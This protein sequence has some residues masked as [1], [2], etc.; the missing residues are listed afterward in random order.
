MITNAE[1]YDGVFHTLDEGSCVWGTAFT[2]VVDE[3]GPGEW[4]GRKLTRKVVEKNSRY[5]NGENNT[6]YAISSFK[7]GKDGLPHRRG[8]NFNATHVITMDDIGDGASAKIPL[9]KVVLPGSFS[10][11]T[12]PGNCQ[13]GYILSEPVHDADLVNRVID[14]LVEQGLA[15]PTDPGMKGVTRY[16]RFPVG[17]NNKKK[18]GDDGWQVRVEEWQPELTYTL[19]DIIDAYGLVLAAPGRVRD[20]GGAEIAA[21]DDPYISVLRDEGLLLD[22][23]VV[24]GDDPPKVDILCPFHEDHGRDRVEE[25]SVYIIGGGFKCFHGSCVDRNFADFKRQ[26]DEEYFVDVEVVHGELLRVKNEAETAA[27]IEMF[28]DLGDDDEDESADD[29]IKVDLFAKFKDAIADATETQLKD[30]IAPSI[31]KVALGYEE[32]EGLIKAYKERYAEVTGL[33]LPLAGLRKRLAGPAGVRKV[34]GN[35][36]GWCENWVYVNSHTAYVDQ[37]KLTVLKT[38]AFNLENGKNIPADENGRKPSAAGFVADHGL[39]DRVDTMNYLPMHEDK[40]VHLGGTTVLNSFNKASVPDAAD[41]FTEAGLAAIEMI[42]NHLLFLCGNKKDAKILLQWLAHQVQ[43][44]GR[45][46]LWSPVIQSIPGAGKSFLATLL[47]YCLGVAN[48]GTVAPA[49]ITSQFNGWAVNVVVNVLEEL[50]VQGHNRYDALNAVKPLITDEIIQINEK[51]VAP[52]MV[53]NTANYICFTNYKDALPLDKYDRRWWVMFAPIEDLDD[54]PDHVGMVADEYFPLL[55]DNVRNNGGILRKWLLEYQITQK[56][57]NTKKAPMTSHKARM[58][59]TE[60]ASI[61]GYQEVRDLIETGNGYFNSDC[62]STSDL[63]SALRFEHPD[64]E[65][66]TI[67]KNMIMKKLGYLQVTGQV[68]IDGQPRRIWTKKE[69]TNEEIRN[70]IGEK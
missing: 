12:S 19:D 44:P 50:R 58:I 25:G 66:N 5:V 3:S 69:M 53:V 51:G 10:I 7:A 30:K 33:S 35:K 52:Y 34:N 26:L 55:F 48:I 24:R 39:I 17:L 56:F 42:K 28:E 18:Y 63:F 20:E 37:E 4:K 40:I 67:K 14:A 70:S 1:F 32:R 61:E 47:R 29:E 23:G 11:E 65:L 38:A 46:M 62:V 54:L 15:S 6:Y 8:N 9:D 43:Y 57:M 68:K 36:P 64:I 21:S 45:Q 2:T 13:I 27:A 49:Q 59:S 22:D 60:E 41:E 16:V 31:A